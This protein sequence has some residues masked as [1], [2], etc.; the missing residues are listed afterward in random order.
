MTKGSMC[1][2]RLCAWSTPRQ[3]P[4][5]VFVD[6]WD[7]NDHSGAKRPGIN[8]VVLERCVTHPRLSS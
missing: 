6:S 1:C 7:I 5:V 3:G 2:E 4:E 8:P